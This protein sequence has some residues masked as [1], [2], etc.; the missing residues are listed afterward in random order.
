MTLV[1]FSVIKDSLMSLIKVA[2]AV[3]LSLLVAGTGMAQTAGGTI[4]GRVL[5]ASGLALPGTTVTLQGTDVTQSFTATE[6]GRY[7]FLDLAPGSYKL[8]IALE[9]FAT[10]VQDNV[11]VN[12]S[13]TVELRTTL[14]ISAFKATVNVTAASPI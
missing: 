8:T 4:T 13:Q 9:G 1:S 3:V 11:A 2:V 5:D 10:A 14:Q 12:P 6:D 7:R